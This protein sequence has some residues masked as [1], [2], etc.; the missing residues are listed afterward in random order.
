MDRHKGDEGLPE[1]FECIHHIEGGDEHFYLCFLFYVH[2]LF[3]V[4]CEA[5]YRNKHAFSG[6]FFQK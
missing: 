2:R 6:Q 1:G 3:V 4:V 5:D